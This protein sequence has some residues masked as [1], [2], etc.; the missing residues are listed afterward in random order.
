MEGVFQFKAQCSPRNK[1]DTRCT[2]PETEYKENRCGGQPH[3]IASSETLARVAWK[4][5]TAE[6]GAAAEAG[7][8]ENS[9]RERDPR[10][11]RPSGWKHEH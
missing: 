2:A 5:R 3:C 4:G 6:D 7:G 9:R 1:A 10:G 11:L 8:P